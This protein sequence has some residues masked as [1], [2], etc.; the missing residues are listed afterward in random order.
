MITPG[1]RLKLLRQSIEQ[2]GFV[3]LMEAHSG[4][5]GI[6]AE[7]A[8]FAMEN[9]SLEFDGFWESSLTDSASQG[10]PDVE[11]VGR[12]ARLAKINEILAV[13]RKPIIVDGDTG[14]SPVEFEY[15]V[16][17]LERRGVSAVIIEDKV[18]PKR[19]SLD[20]SARQTLED[21]SEF[22]QKIQRGKKEC[23]TDEFMIIARLESLIAGTGLE[24]ALARA[25]TYMQAGVDG[26][27]IH[28]QKD[29]P[30][31]ILA[32]AEAFQSLCRKLEKRLPL[33][34][35]PTTY[36][37]I[38]DRE[39]AQHGFNI[40]IHA[41]HLL[42]SS[43]KAMQQ[44]AL[45]ILENDRGFEAEP[46]CAP[47]SEIFAAVGFDRIKEQDRQYSSDQRLSVIIPTAGKDPVFPDR[48]KSMINVG[49]K[50]ILEHQLEG[51]RKAGLTNNQVVVVR[52][53]EAEQ[54]TRADV[55]FRDND[56]Y[57]DTHS[58]HSLFCAESAMEE[59]FVLVYSDILFNE[60]LIRRLVGCAGDIV[61]LIDNSYRYHT[62]TVD[63]QLD[64]VISGRQHSSQRRRL[65]ANSLV[66]IAK[67]GKG[68]STEM[69]DFEFVGIAYFSEEGAEI[70]RKVYRDS[71]AQAGSGF[72]EAPNFQRATITDILQEIIDRGF[73]V[74][75]QETS[76][77]WIEIHNLQDI[78]VAEE[79]LV[80]ARVAGA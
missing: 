3:R 78:G 41:N 36:N 72:H 17:D 57:L 45:A 18:F 76:M 80:S 2:K 43:Y 63:K 71:Q 4:I 11:I 32:F 48:P 64:M 51:L 34:C 58:L 20:T 69:A 12:E 59:G 61:L 26:I 27:M 77:G 1:D 38:T 54:L 39:L 70:L 35:V 55:A 79:E 28:S 19:N 68:I 56:R 73:K 24:D 31:E 62:H 29:R 9:E 67:I 8:S 30:D 52:G 15:L 40:M 14:R 75:G 50:T 37:L 6:V 44:T 13:T 10:L 23:L 49:G 65:Q 53:H 60:D 47:T 66:D 25:E 16:R 22:A 42:R 33:V 74:Q 21:P 7:R 46:L 5:S